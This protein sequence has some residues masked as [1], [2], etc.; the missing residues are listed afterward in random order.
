MIALATPWLGWPTPA[1]I[2]AMIGVLSGVRGLRLAMASPAQLAVRAALLGWGALL[3]RAAIG[4]HVRGVV[5]MLGSLAGARGGGALAVAVLL[6]ALTLA[7]GAALAWAGATL[8]AGI[9]G[10]VTASAPGR[11]S[12]S[13]TADVA[14]A[15]RAERAPAAPTP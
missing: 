2:G 4:G 1:V 5:A 10:A 3:A 15:R 6:A 8:I 13:G 14:P 11:V 9:V 12:L 7:L